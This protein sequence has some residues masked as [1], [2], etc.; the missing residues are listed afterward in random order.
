M[1]KTFIVLLIVAP[2]LLVGAAFTI[3]PIWTISISRIDIEGYPVYTVYRN[4]FPFASAPSKSIAESYIRQYS[5]K[6]T[7]W[8]YDSSGNPK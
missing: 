8:E 5:N 2:V 7:S 1:K 4:G 3:T 6:P